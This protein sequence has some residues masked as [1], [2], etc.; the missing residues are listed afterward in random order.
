[1]M[2]SGVKQWMPRQEV[3]MDWLIEKVLKPGRIEMKLK[4]K[5]GLLMIWA[6]VLVMAVPPDVFAQD[7]GWKPSLKHESLSRCWLQSRS[8]LTLCSPRY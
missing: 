5:C 6:L 2:T 8:T 1:M 3:Q 4:Q 7:A